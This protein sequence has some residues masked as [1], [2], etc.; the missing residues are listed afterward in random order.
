MLIPL[1]FFIRTYLWSPQKHSASS[2]SQFSPHPFFTS[3]K[4]S[5]ADVCVEVTAD[6]KLKNRYL[7]LQM[8]VKPR[9]PR[10]KCLPVCMDFR[11]CVD[12]SMTKPNPSPACVKSKECEECSRRPEEQVLLISYFAPEYLE[13]RC[14]LT[15]WTMCC[16]YLGYGWLTCAVPAQTSI[17][18]GLKLTSGSFKGMDG[19]PKKTTQLSCVNSTCMQLRTVDTKS[20]CPHLL[21]HP[22]WEKFEVPVRVEPV[23]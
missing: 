21:Y 4:R 17:A 13:L 3:P 22:R 7:L 12:A 14:K 18:M 19:I 1:N 8:A 15:V 16:M 9:F 20:S 5:Y 23:F 10:G 6:S 2:T 11:K